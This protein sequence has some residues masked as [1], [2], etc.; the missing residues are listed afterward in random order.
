MAIG[1]WDFLMRISRMGCEFFILIGWRQFVGVTIMWW[2]GIFN[3]NCENGMRI[4]LIG[5][6]HMLP[7]VGGRGCLFL[8]GV[9]G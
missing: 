8:G 7:G 5:G 2:V 9:G 3:A 4:F 6:G 1:G